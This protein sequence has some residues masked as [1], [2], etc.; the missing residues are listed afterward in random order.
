MRQYVL[1]GEGLSVTAFYHLQ[2]LVRVHPALPDLA[3]H[4]V[5]VRREV[6]LVY[7]YFIPPLVRPPER[8]YALVLS[9]IHISAR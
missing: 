1:H 6:E 4:G 2:D 8:R 3:R 5:A 9:L 7:Y